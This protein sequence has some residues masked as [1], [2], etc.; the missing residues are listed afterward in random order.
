MQNIGNTLAD[1]VE[2]V[3]RLGKSLNSDL[4]ETQGLINTIEQE[5]MRLKQLNKYQVH[6][7]YDAEPLLNKDQKVIVFRMLQETLNNILK[8]ARGENISIALSGKNHFKMVIKDDGKGFD[9]NEMIRS[10]NGS[11][12]KNMMKRAE[13]AKLSCYFESAIGKGT[14]FTLE[15]IK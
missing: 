13:L 1:T 4:F 12:L 6:W 11:G 10:P 7:K 5:V 8:H 14:T 2:E 15:Q 9:Y 3:K